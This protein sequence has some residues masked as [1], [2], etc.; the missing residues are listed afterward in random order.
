VEA[1]A[2]A[3]RPVFLILGHD[4]GYALDP[5]PSLIMQVSQIVLN[6]RK[7]QLRR[8]AVYTEGTL[9]GICEYRY[10]YQ[11]V[12]VDRIASGHVGLPYGQ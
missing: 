9:E 7:G 8:Y 11:F 12:P 10:R 4:V 5:G 6:R 1:S 2:L 3:N